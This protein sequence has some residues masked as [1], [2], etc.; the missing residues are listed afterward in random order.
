MVGK[1]NVI[2]SRQNVKV[3]ERVIGVDSIRAFAA[4]SV[5]LAH[6]LGPILPDMLSVT[7]RT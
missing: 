4:L 6:I 2:S 5:M 7:R 3:A 1:L